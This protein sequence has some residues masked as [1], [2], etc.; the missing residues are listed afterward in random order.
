MG[1]KAVAGGTCSCS[2]TGSTGCG[3]SA[4]C[5]LASPS[6]PRFFAGQVLSDLDLIALERYVI[7]KNQLHNRYLHGSGVVCGLEIT[8]DDCSDNLI[9]ECGYALDCH[10]RDIVVPS[11]QSFDLGAAIRACLLAGRTRPVCD[12]PINQPPTDCPDD[13]TWCVTL[14]YREADIRPQKPLITGSS[15]CGGTGTGHGGGT[16]GCGSAPT[17]NG[18]SGCGCGGT[19]SSGGSGGTTT[20]AATCGCSTG[21]F[22][23]GCEPTRTIECFELGVCRDDQQ[24]HNLSARLAGSMPAQII[25]CLRDAWAKVSRQVDPASQKLNAKLAMG[26]ATS[27]DAGAAYAAVWRLHAAMSDLVQGCESPSP[28]LLQELAAAKPTAQLA[29]ESN[30][31]Y[32]ARSGTAVRQLLLLAVLYARDCICKAM[33]PPCPP[34]PDDDRII[35][36]CVTFRDGKAQTICNLSCRKYAGSFVNREY[37]L[38][39]LPVLTWAAGLLCCLPIVRD[40]RGDRRDLQMLMSAHDPDGVLRD[41]LLDNDFAAVR[42][43]FT[44]AGS[45]RTAFRRSLSRFAPQ[46]WAAGRV[47]LS[48]ALGTNVGSA[49]RLLAKRR[50]EVTEVAVDSR[51]DI[52]LRGMALL[53]LVAPGSRVTAYVVDGKI[54][55]F[56]AQSPET[57]A[58]QPEPPTGQ[59]A[60]DQAEPR[61]SRAKGSRGGG[62]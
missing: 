7:A 52:P 39:V 3:C 4:G 42:D 19:G 8:R 43:L 29:E 57:T 13:G 15:G 14:R 21:S 16:C 61:T 47:T 51:D 40:Q 35:L 38:P 5:D 60:P 9:V 58:A 2:G 18:S 56:R 45:V 1:L 59:A 44:R 48:D 22:A 23:P 53:P 27:R 36:G 20:I 11:R 34:C 30:A 10:G 31:V 50:I 32:V 28:E 54:A 25:A 12:P 37:W 17:S 62:G 24:C 49:R 26:K 6:R 41:A 33:L 46:R 55:A